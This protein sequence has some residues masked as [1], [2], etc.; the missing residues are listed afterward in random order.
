MNSY[1]STPPFFLFF[2]KLMYASLMYASS[3][4]FDLQG[5][6]NMVRLKGPLEALA[7]EES[8]LQRAL[9]RMVNVRRLHYVKHCHGNRPRILW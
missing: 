6:S 4:G 2:R 3:T 5:C 1:Y 9:T 7:V 8:P